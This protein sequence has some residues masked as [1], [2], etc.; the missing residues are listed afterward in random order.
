LE[1]RGCPEPYRPLE[2]Y[3]DLLACLPEYLTP[4]GCSLFA[5]NSGLFSARS[6]DLGSS[7]SVDYFLN[8]AAEPVS[9]NLTIH[10]QAHASWR[11]RSQM[12]REWHYP[13]VPSRWREKR[14]QVA[15]P[16]ESADD[17][18][19]VQMLVNLPGQR[20]F[21]SCYCGK[22]FE[23]GRDLSQGAVWI[24]SIARKRVKF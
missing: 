24:P 14:S 4:K 19:V 7:E 23:V 16:A 18:I 20:Q 15:A 22:R 9:S 3:A 11:R 5:T 8:F 6:L 17:A 2:K 10:L 21:R 1:R 12:V 13:F